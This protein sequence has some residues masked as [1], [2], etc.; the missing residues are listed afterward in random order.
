MTEAQIEKLFHKIDATHKGFIS[1]RDYKIALQGYAID[2]DI[3]D[4]ILAMDQDLDGKITLSEFTDHMKK[5]LIPE[6]SFVFP[7]NFHDIDW[8]EVFVHFDTDGSG[9]LSAQ[10]LKEILEAKGPQL[11]RETIIEI[12]TSLDKN[13]DG[14]LSYAEFI[15]HFT[16]G[17]PT[18]HLDILV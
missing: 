14:S 2:K 6:P 11:P 18:E 17:T 3:R 10:E 16:Q 13:F 1:Q 5:A 4:T 15:R 7:D 8:F 9:T 12:F